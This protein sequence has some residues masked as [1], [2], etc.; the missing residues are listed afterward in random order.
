MNDQ[1]AQPIFLRS[2]TGSLSIM[3]LRLLLVIL[4][5]AVM[6]TGVKTA[7]QTQTHHESY[8][9][10]QQLKKELTVMQVE[11]QR[12][13]I[14]Q[15]TFSATPQVARRAVSELGMFFPVGDSRRVIAPSATTETDESD[16]TKVAP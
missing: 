2:Q 3:G 12:L 4:V 13:L 15:Q 8:R 6:F 14:E 10:L 16:T 9:K 11:Q 1:V 7:V 5:V